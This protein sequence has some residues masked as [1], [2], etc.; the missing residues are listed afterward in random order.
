MEMMHFVCG[1]GRHHRSRRPC[2]KHRSAVSRRNKPRVR[3]QNGTLQMQRHNKWRVTR[4]GREARGGGRPGRRKCHS[5]PPP[6]QCPRLRSPLQR[7]PDG[8]PTEGLR[9]GSTANQILP[10]NCNIPSKNKSVFYGICET[11][12][13]FV[14][15]SS[16]KK[17]RSAMRYT[18][19]RTVSAERAARVFES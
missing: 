11:L 5:R 2:L 14:L 16:L 6:E 4:S 8:A 13:T 3:A 19:Y 15:S 9:N 7:P 12:A 18:L 17:T 10:N 1:R